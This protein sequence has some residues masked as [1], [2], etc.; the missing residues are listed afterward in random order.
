MVFNNEARHTQ[1]T[2]R[3]LCDLAMLGHDPGEAT[4]RLAAAAAGHPDGNARARA[5]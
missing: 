1:F 3:P 2:G 4:H 5:M